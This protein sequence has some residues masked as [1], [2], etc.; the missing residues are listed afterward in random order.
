MI[1]IKQEITDTFET[2][3]LSIPISV[4]K[5]YSPLN[6][7]LFNAQSHEVY[8]ASNLA[9]SSFSEH[10]IVLVFSKEDILKLQK[11]YYSYAVRDDDNN[12]IASGLLVMEGENVVNTVYENEIKNV[13]YNG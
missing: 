11:G 3:E 6:F 9:N 7:T 10:Y 13:I 4:S 1:Y 2:I 5:F 12:L 8:F